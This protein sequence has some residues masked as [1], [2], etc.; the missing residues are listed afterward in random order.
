VPKK[1]SGPTQK[2]AL[3]QKAEKLHS[4]KPRKAVKEVTGELHLSANTIRTF[5]AR[6]LEKIGA[7][8]TSELIHYAIARNLTEP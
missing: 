6:I 2:A 1:T 3:R 5:R 8:G 4:E 7:K